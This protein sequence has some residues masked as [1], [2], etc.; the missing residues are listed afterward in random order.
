MKAVNWKSLL[1]K[2]LVSCPYSAK[3]MERLCFRMTVTQTE[4]TNAY[5]KYPAMCSAG[6]EAV[7]VCEGAT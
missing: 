4:T 6:G 2:I 1:R 3:C 5:V 7:K